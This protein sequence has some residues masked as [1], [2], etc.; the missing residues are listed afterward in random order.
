MGAVDRRIQGTQWAR[1]ASQRGWDLRAR[2]PLLE[3]GRQTQAELGVIDALEIQRRGG[4]PA[5]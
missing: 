2:V 3:E 5:V 4:L 1:R